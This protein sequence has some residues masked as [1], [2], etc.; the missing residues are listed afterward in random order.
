MGP[1]YENFRE[2]VELLRV[3]NALR[4]TE[5]VEGG[6]AIVALL[7]DAQAAAVMGARGKKVFEEQAGATGR[8][9][10]AVVRLLAEGN[11]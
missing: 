11:A 5:R 9:V 7:E 4:L 6:D 8:A 2:A 10:D 3:A 1:H